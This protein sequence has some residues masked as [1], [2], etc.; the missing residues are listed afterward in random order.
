MLTSVTR[1]ITEDKEEKAKIQ[2]ITREVKIKNKTRKRI[3]KTTIKV[4][5]V[6]HNL[7]QHKT[8]LTSSRLTLALF[9]TT[10]TLTV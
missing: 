1:R 6:M 5:R 8:P 3:T 7:R 9:R 10:F 4:I 2:Q